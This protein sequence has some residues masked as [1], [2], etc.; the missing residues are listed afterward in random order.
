MTAYHGIQ[1]I[2]ARNGRISKQ[3]SINA[4]PLGQFEEGNYQEL[5]TTN[6]K[7]TRNGIR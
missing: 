1:F 3:V 2:S 4:L 6:L 7:G 5:T